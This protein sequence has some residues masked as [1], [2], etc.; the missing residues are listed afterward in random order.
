MV[1]LKINLF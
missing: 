1:G